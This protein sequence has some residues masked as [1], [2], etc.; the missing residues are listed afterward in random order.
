MAC[1]TTRRGGVLRGELMDQR[2]PGQ[3]GIDSEAFGQG[4][5]RG[6]TLQSWMDR[7]R[8]DAYVRA[9]LF[10]QDNPEWQLPEGDPEGFTP[11]QRI[12]FARMNDYLHTGKEPFQGQDLVTAMRSVK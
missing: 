2:S 10:P 5:E 12:Q 6:D 1:T 3:R 7:S 9:G 11:Q 4:H 8:S